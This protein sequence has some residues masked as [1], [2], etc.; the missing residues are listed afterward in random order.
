MSM[1]TYV[2]AGL[3][4][5]VLATV[6]A[7]ANQ[8]PPKPRATK[9]VS[10]TKTAAKK[11][12]IAH[13]RK[14]TAQA[15]TAK[16]THTAVVNK[17][18]SKSSSGK[19]NVAAKSAVKAAAKSKT[20]VVAI[21]HSATSKPAKSPAKSQIVAVAAR[22][23]PTAKLTPTHTK[24]V[25]KPLASQAKA[26][27]GTA[28]FAVAQNH[29]GAFLDPI[30][31][32][33]DGRFVSPP[34]GDATTAQI[35]KFANTYYRAEQKYRLLF[36]GGEAGSVTVKQWNLR[37]E[38]ARTQASAEID[39]E[40]AK[41]NGKVMGLATNSKSLGQ[42]ARSRR[43]PTEMEKN[44]ILALAE[45]LYKQKGLTDA[46]LKDLKRV[47]ITATDLNGDG[48]AEL[49]GTFMVKRPVGARIAHILFVIAEPNGK[50]YK[51]SASQYGQITANDVGG[52]AKLDELGES[53]LAEIL[54]DQIDL[55][56]DGTAE[57]IIADTTAEGVAYKIFKK[58]KNV[59]RK[60]Y[61]F[62]NLRCAN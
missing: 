13:T 49:I 62:Y 59:W 4:I 33:Q 1:R 53:A 41:I 57:V 58:Q 14:V 18:S 11:P 12:A 26:F 40:A 35:T 34:A 7:N 16:T 21:N 32:I 25:A 47:N 52:T 29:K 28:L 27:N 56:K 55:D 24:T 42:K 10:T 60:A 9:S 44:A 22:K 54:V 36:G 51:A 6:A 31:L 30:V 38:C 37:K 46:E 23:K 20:K 15:K 48:K 61:E 5:I 45:R 43:F 17:S 3:A 8:T 2:L 39:S 50:T 19:K